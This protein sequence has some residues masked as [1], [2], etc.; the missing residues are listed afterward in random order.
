[1]DIL[2]RDDLEE[3]KAFWEVENVS[4]LFNSRRHLQ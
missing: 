1:M 3:L 4:R 2:V